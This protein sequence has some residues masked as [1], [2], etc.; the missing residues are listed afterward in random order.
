M[1]ALLFA[2]MFVLLFATMFVLLFANVCFDVCVDVCVD[3][4]SPQSPEEEG[5]TATPHRWKLPPWRA[6]AP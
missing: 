1:F 2:S 5:D 3:I 6:R 4:R